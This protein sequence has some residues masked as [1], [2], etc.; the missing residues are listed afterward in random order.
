MCDVALVFHVEVPFHLTNCFVDFLFIRSG[1]DPIV[2]VHNED[3][4]AAE[5]DALVDF[6]LFEANGPLQS[7]DKMLVPYSSSLFD[8]RGF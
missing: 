6:G 2:G 8:R 4:I 3:D 5:E 7:L 1:K